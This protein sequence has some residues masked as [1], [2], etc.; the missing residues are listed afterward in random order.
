MRQFTISEKEAG[1][2]LDKLLARLMPEAPRSFFYRM[3][4]KKNITL[5]GKKA[6]GG[7][8]L[9]PG[10]ELKLFISEESYRKFG[11]IDLPAAKH[12]ESSPIPGR[13]PVLD[14]AVTPPSIVYGDE[15][16]LL[17]DKPA[18]ILSQ[19][20]KSAEP[21][22]VEYLNA[23]LLESG[24]M[25][26]EELAFVHPSVC[27]RLDRN[28]S[29]LV[30]AGI[31]LAGLQCLSRLFRERS[32]EKYYR[33]IVCGEL[34]E[35]E[36]L[37]GYLKKDEKT[38]RVLVLSAPANG[39]KPVEIQYRSLSC[40][41][42]LSLLEVHLITGRSHQIRAQLSAAGHPVLGDPK[43]GDADINRAYRKS[44]GVRNQLLHAYLIRFPQIGGPLSYL[45][46]RSFCAEMPAV[47]DRLMEVNI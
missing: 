12:R 25:T 22:L 2:R 37:K 9:K 31:S 7:I 20:S 46:G 18:G 3:L 27:N 21:S 41:N 45:G 30:A 1:Q 29:G 6:E 5:N 32:V 11:G 33:C 28:T 38:N 40:T 4:R 13:V 47:F 44:H 23:Y 39:A 24:R 36:T 14:P 16:I 17:F 19:G 8:L 10:D 42:A 34:K 35:S 15:N 26:K 43:Y